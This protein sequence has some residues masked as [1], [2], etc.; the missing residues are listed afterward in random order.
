MPRPGY[1]EAPDKVL[2]PPLTINNL[3]QN[4]R[5]GFQWVHLKEVAL[6]YSQLRQILQYRQCSLPIEP[7]GPNPK[8]PLNLEGQTSPYPIDLEVMTPPHTYLI[9]CSIIV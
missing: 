6:S 1:E 2:H 3:P 9:N 7:L 4:A 8:R 5:R